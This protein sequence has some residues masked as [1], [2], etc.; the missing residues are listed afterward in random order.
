MRSDRKHATIP[1]PVL[2]DIPSEFVQPDVQLL[3]G[4]DFT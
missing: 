3:D 1:V 4:N 2:D